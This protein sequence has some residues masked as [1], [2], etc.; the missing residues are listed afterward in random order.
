MPRFTFAYALCTILA[1]H[2]D[3]Q[4]TVQTTLPEVQSQGQGHGSVAN[5]LLG[6]DNQSDVAGS[7]VSTSNLSDFSDPVSTRGDHTVLSNETQIDTV[8]DHD[9]D[10]VSGII[11]S[12][13]PGFSLY[14]L[15]TLRAQN[16]K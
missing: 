8:Q 14:F 1:D 15:A 4:L 7:L 16:T 11:V 5:G 12:D 2:P 6:I 13:T 9:K 3:T 10:F